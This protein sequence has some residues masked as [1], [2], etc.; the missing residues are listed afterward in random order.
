[1]I[2][3]EEGQADPFERQRRL[4]AEVRLPTHKLS[5]FELAVHIIGMQFI[6]R[7]RGV[8]QTSVN[9]DPLFATTLSFTST[10]F[11]TKFLPGPH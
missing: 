9:P 3:V 1:V 6:S 11:A 8:G 4:D 10:S 2:G 7:L 5:R